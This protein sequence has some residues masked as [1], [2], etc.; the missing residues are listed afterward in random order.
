M[1]PLLQILMVMLLLAPAVQADGVGL[2]IGV[3]GGMAFP[4]AQ[5][6]Q[7]RGGTAEIRALV[8]L[9]PSIV[10]QPN[11]ALARY[12]EPEFDEIAADLD[13]SDITGY[14]V[15]AVLGGAF[16]ARGIWPYGLV[17]VGFYKT[18][19]DQTDEDAT[20]FGWSVGFGVEWGVSERVGV[21]V[22][23]ALRVISA[24]GGG[25]EK[26]ASVT[27]GLNFYLGN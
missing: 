3:A 1:K 27:G 18:K 25:T 8:Q 5:D 16:A 11:V 4:I 9:M 19:R 17:G 6:D 10:I 7:A 2:G 26:A 13:G 14:G 21:D 20:D 15:D 24:D 22:R 12:G 23:S